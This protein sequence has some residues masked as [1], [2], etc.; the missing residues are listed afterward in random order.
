MSRAIRRGTPE[1]DATLAL[2][3]LARSEGADVQELQTLYALE[4]LLARVAAS[5]FRDDFVLKGGALL[6]AYA[7]RRPTK[8]LDLSAT[9]LSNDTAGVTERVRSICAI[10][11]PDGVEFDVG[12]ISASE[13]RDEDEY[14]GVR[15]R[16]TGTLGAAR[17]HVGID[18]SFGDP[19]WP[20][21]RI[22]QVPRLLDVGLEPVLV[23][24]YPLTMVL[25]EK[26]VTA[27]ERGEANTRWRDFA[28]VH[29]VSR[30]HRIDGDTLRSSL[31]E[32]A[33]YREGG[34]APAER[35]GGRTGCRRAG[36][37]DPL[38]PPWRENRPLREPVGGARP[39][40]ALRRS[41]DHGTGPARHVV[42]GGTA[43]GRRRGHQGDLVTAPGRGKGSVDRDNGWRMSG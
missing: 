39:R 7:L 26:I 13:I 40:R 36:T 3:A 9:R 37:M 33:Q 22:V 21:P 35:R 41:R 15:L 1:D 16:I 17:L 30:Q 8:D 29:V 10:P 18:V 23:L 14:S 4:C 25:A 42:T 2:R 6:A 12:S 11:L 43:L 24:G 28:D 34:D 5:P 27:V 38:A 32:V 20:A 31:R 19:I